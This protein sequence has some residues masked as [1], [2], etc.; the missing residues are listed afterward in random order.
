ML[1]CSLMTKLSVQ[2]LTHGDEGKEVAWHENV[3]RKFNISQRVS[4]VRAEE[5]V[6][7][8][9]PCLEYVVCTLTRFSYEASG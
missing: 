4:A 1:M 8:L 7:A 6:P 3:S 5:Y 2:T 9:R